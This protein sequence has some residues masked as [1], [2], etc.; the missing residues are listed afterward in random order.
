MGE[1]LSPSGKLCHGSAKG[2]HQQHKDRG[3]SAANTRPEVGCL[4]AGHRREAMFGSG[5]HRGWRRAEQCS[6]CVMYNRK[7][8][9]PHPPPL[10]ATDALYG[11]RIR[12]YF[13]GGFRPRQAGKS[14]LPDDT[15]ESSSGGM[16]DCSSPP[17]PP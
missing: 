9:G 10:W 1:Q 13:W 3:S 6:P 12:G 16:T 2:T 4:A 14:L 15:R 7:V 5:A 11:R 17:P 8:V